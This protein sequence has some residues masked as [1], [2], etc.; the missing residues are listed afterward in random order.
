MKFRIADNRRGIA[1]MTGL[2]RLVHI[3]G[4]I[5]RIALSATVNPLDAIAAFVAGRDERGTPRPIDVI[6]GTDP[7]KIEF[8]VRFPEHVRAAQE[9][10][11]KIWSALTDSFKGIIAGNASTLFFT[12][13]RRIAERITLTINDAEKE[14]LAYAHHGSLSREIRT[15]VEARL[16]SGAMRA[17]V[18]TNSLE[19]G[20]DIGSIDEVVMISRRRRSPSVRVSAAP[21]TAW[22]VPAGAR[23]SRRMHTIFSKR[24]H[25]PNVSGALEPLAT[26]TIARRTRA[27]HRVDDASET[28]RV[29]VLR[30]LRRSHPIDHCRRN[31]STSSSEMLAGRYAGSRVRDLKARVVYDRIEQTLRAAEAVYALQLRRRF[32]Q[33]YYHLRHN[34]TGALDVSMK[35]S[36]GKPSWPDFSLGTQ[37]WQIKHINDVLAVPAKVASSSPPPESPVTAA[38]FYSDG[39]AI[40][41]S[42]ERRIADGEQ[43]GFSAI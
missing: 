15:E 12:N 42:A 40:F 43:A 36:S 1:L 17:I 22:A 38:V 32:D 9:N 3:A 24:R 16:K 30:D 39:S 14:P 29:D 35:S 23:C 21:D 33:G 11:Q 25:S 19:M 10:G 7:K 8:S 27:D 41:S 37:H 4:D 20:I 6:V 26:P 31:S 2:E 13:S 18:A 5:Q 34:D 28:W